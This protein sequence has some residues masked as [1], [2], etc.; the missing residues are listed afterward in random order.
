MGQTKMPPGIKNQVYLEDIVIYSKDLT[1]RSL[2]YME[3]KM[4]H[5]VKTEDD[6]GWYPKVRQPKVRQESTE[7]MIIYDSKWYPK[8]RQE[9]AEPRRWYPKVWQE[10]TEPMIIYDSRWY[11]KAR[12]ELTE[13]GNNKKLNLNLC[14][15]GEWKS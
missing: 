11:P 5:Y 4:P 6:I 8:V 3:D 15:P 14:S 7:P 9:S 1:G 12:Q 2:T 10:S 13:P